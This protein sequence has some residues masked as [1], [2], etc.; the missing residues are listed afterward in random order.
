MCVMC[1]CSYLHA[2]LTCD[3]CFSFL[4]FLPSLNHTFVWGKINL[5]TCRRVVLCVCLLKTEMNKHHFNKIKIGLGLGLGLGLLGI[6]EV[7]RCGG[8][9]GGGFLPRGALPLVGSHSG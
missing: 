4:C 8:R 3:I 5:V 1:V 9:R 2:C 6:L 7:N